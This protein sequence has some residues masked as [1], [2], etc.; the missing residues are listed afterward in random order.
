MKK[1]YFT[2]IVILVFAIL[3]ISPWEVKGA[4][5]GDSKNTPR[6]DPLVDEFQSHDPKAVVNHALDY[7]EQQKAVS[8]DKKPILSQTI[9]PQGVQENVPEIIPEVP[10]DNFSSSPGGSSLE[11]TQEIRGNE[12]KEPEKKSAAG[13]IPPATLTGKSSMID[14]L[15]LKNVDIIDVLKLIADKSGLDI[16]AGRDVVGKVSIYLK[17]VSVKDAL[18]IILDSYNL[19]YAE[20]NGVIRIMTDKDFQLKYGYKFGERIETRILKLNYSDVSELGIVL[21]QM[22]TIVGR[23]IPEKTTNTLII[24]DI[25]EKI[26]ILENFVKQV[27]VPRKTKVFELNYATAEDV[28]KKIT[29]TLT[30]NIGKVEIDARSNKIIVTDIPVRM[31]QIENIIRAVDVKVKEVL[32]EARIVQIVLSDQYQMG[33]NWEAVVSNYH[34]LDLSNNFQILDSSSTTRQGKLSIGTIADDDYT[35]LIQALQTVGTTNL[36]SS[37]RITVINNK[38]AKIIVGSTEPYT[39][40]TTVTPASGP[41]TTSE[42]VNFIEVGV[43]LYVTPTVHNDGYITMQIKPEVSSVTR[44]ITTSNNNTIPVVETSQAETTVAVKDGVTIV[45][46]GLMKDEKIKT[47]KRVPLLGSIPAIGAAFRSTDDSVKKTELVIFL[48]PRIITGDY[49]IS[50]RNDNKNGF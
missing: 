17:E 39:T 38:E 18:R 4:L 20:D 35:T 13:D 36:L 41:T 22:K 49:D 30:K 43:K 33:V 5:E 34:K 48:T 16:V 2:I 46:G 25:P 9:P 28:S 40:S 11:N 42:S 14:S 32:I 7:F 24:M 31:A 21:N 27:D 3:N 6:V 45:I 12:Q 15:E 8:A 37:P 19:A 1:I 29:E 47:V 26:D 10:Q 50:G 23:I 44:T